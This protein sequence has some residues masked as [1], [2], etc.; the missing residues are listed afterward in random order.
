MGE[1]PA[2]TR[3]LMTADCVGGVFTYAMTLASSLARRRIGV[4]LAVMGDLMRPEQRAAAICIPG[5]ALH[6]RPF[7]L[8][9]MDDPWDDVARAAD[10]LVQLEREVR[11]DVVHLN[12]FCHG[13]AG[14]RA[15]KVVVGHA[16]VI[17]WWE[18]VL[19]EQAPARYD[20]YRRAVRRGLGGA[21]A[22]IAPS[23]AMLRSLE[24][25]YVGPWLDDVPRRV[26][27]NGAAPV[28][29]RLL[30]KEPFVLSAGRVWDR[31]KNLEA[32]AS[33]APR[34]AWPVKV[35][36]SDMHPDGV[37]RP[38]Q[39][40]EQLGWLD[41]PRLGAI[42]DRAAIF[43]LP[44]RYEPFGLCPLEAAQRGCALVVG[45]IESLHEVWGDAAL[46]VAPEDDEAIARTISD[47]SH[48]AEARAELA[49]RAQARAASFTAERLVAETL[50]VYEL[51]ARGPSSSAEVDSSP[52]A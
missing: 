22:V 2:R 21:N 31:A 6:E 38:L 49:A 33:V 16:C 26:V 28:P 52:Y 43:A 32:L 40:V 27:H 4:D 9:W 19:G 35:A 5:L 50:A 18:A 45:D 17:S 12:G 3:V 29:P 23:R 24:K 15:T 8:E 36:G 11:P 20:T 51:A 39:H 42:M 30:A 37:R 41:A 47:L 14:F 44:A 48:D 13:D 7:A 25:H 10:W 34:L 1:R 46:F